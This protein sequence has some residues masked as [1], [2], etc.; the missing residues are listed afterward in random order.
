MKRILWLVAVVALALGATGATAKT[1]SM[2]MVDD[3]LRVQVD[4]R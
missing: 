3:K 2:P 1:G 4:C